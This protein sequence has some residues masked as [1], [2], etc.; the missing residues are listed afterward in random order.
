MRMFNKKSYKVIGETDPQVCK[1]CSH[2]RAFKVVEEKDWLTF[3]VIPLVPYKKRNLAVCSV[4]GAGF[5]FNGEVKVPLEHKEDQK[6]IDTV[7]KSIKER[8][9]RG[10][11]TKN[12]FI[13]MVNALKFEAQH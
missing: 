1:K 3:I 5:E 12:E 10:E 9:D 4:C 11:I 7:Y 2:E 8:F 13:R 6:T